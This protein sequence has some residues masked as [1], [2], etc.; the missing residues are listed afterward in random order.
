MNRNVGDLLCSHVLI[1]TVRKLGLIW[2]HLLVGHQYVSDVWIKEQDTKKTC[3]Q[4]LIRN[5]AF[6]INSKMIVIV[7]TNKLCD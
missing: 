2:S 7:C 6:R 5:K 4:N 1:S 3:L